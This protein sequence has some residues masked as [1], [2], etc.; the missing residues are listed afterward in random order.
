MR[1]TTLPYYLCFVSI[2]DVCRVEFDSM[3]WRTNFHL[4]V[5]LPLTGAH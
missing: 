1:V 5:T 2:L 3:R 4:A